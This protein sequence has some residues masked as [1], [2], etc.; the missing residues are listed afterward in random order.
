MVMLIGVEKRFIFIANSKTASTSIEE[1]LIPYAE[2]NRVGSP[3][4]KHIKWRDARK[5]YRFL[6]DLPSYNPGSF[7]KFGVVREPVEWV[8]SWYN[9]RL[10]NL[11]V[12]S[13]VPHEM[14]FERFW[15]SNDWVKRISQ[16]DFFSGWDGVCRFD[17]VIPHERVDQVFPLV[18]KRLGLGR[19]VLPRKN[20]SIVKKVVRAN[21][22]DQ[23]ACDVNDHY[24]RDFDFWME[25]KD[26]ANKFV[27]EA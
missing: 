6:F 9:Y 11:G 26:K 4:R 13:G 3:Q 2:I 25:W 8:I 15:N 20:Q 21:L 17:L 12:E 7:F 14:S 22:D 19:I 23:L 24:K 1:A 16:T 5:E 27:G 18:V 10:G